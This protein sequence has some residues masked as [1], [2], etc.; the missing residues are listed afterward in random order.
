VKFPPTV[1]VPLTFK[2]LL[3]VKLPVTIRF[4]ELKLKDTLGFITKSPFIVKVP[5]LRF[6]EPDVHVIS[7]LRTILFPELIVKLPLSF[8]EYPVNTEINNMTNSRHFKED[9]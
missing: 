8:T 6:I 2:G 7:V 3:K 1:N 9:K 4:P 5:P